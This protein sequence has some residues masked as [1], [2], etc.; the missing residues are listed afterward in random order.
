MTIKEMV[1]SE[2]SWDAANT[3]FQFIQ[4]LD[5]DLSGI[6]REYETRLK[7]VIAET[8]IDD[9]MVL[10]S[11]LL[12]KSGTLIDRL[13]ELITATLSDRLMPE[14]YAEWSKLMDDLED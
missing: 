10:Y 14:D 8:P 9:L 4:L 13:E 5:N 11:L 7:N 12:D 2:K 6:M 1:N 3:L